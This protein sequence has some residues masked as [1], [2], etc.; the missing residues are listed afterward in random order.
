MK[1]KERLMDISEGQRVRHIKTG[2]TYVVVAI[3]RVEAQPDERVVV[4][5]KI[6]PLHRKEALPLTDNTWSRPL[7]EFSD[8]R[9][10]KIATR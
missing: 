6:D 9:F 5:R 1:V 10:V 4:Y 8:G 2:G 7:A 3:A